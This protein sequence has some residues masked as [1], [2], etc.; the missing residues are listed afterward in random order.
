MCR[1]LFSEPLT[2]NELYRLKQS[3]PNLRIDIGM[4]VHGLNIDKVENSAKWVRE[5]LP[6]DKLKPILV[7][8]NPLNPS[9]LD[10][11]CTDI[12]HK[13]VDR[14]SQYLLSKSKA[15]KMLDRLI[16]AKENV[17]R[18]LIK[19]ISQTNKSR[20]TCSGGRETAVMY[21]TGDIAGCEMRDDILGNIRDANYDFKSVWLSK[22]GDKFRKTVGKVEACTGCYHHCFIAPAIFRT[23]KMWLKIA[24]SILKMNE[25]AA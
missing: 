18:Q 4:V 8:G 5:N 22:K 20:I 10:K 13:I 16:H 7:R 21:P 17:S 24:M 2:V 12:Y 3:Y 15:P 1:L 25:K 11:H 9:T 6:I 14:D 23:P 19:E